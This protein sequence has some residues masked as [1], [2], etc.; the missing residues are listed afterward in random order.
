MLGV[1][2][3]EADELTY[4]IRPPS[5]KAG[6]KAAAKDAEATFL[7]HISKTDCT[8]CPDPELVDPPLIPEE[9]PRQPPAQQNTADI[10][11]LPS[12]DS[13]PMS[14]DRAPE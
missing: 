14:L 12:I 9:P 10:G 3:I 6:D 13:S 5:V 7:S 11:V 8:N 4:T 1:G 2:P